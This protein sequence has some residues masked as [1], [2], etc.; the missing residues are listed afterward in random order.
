MPKDISDIYIK[1][2]KDPGFTENKLENQTFVDTV[3]A[4]IYMILMTNKGEVLGNPNFGAD[5]P[6][7]LWKTMLPAS[8][9]QNEIT[10][11][12][13]QYVPELS[14]NDY[15]VNVYILPG[16]TQ[17]VGVIEINLGITSAVVLYK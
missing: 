12:I 1:D 13:T 2:S 17:D 11:Q 6:K 3:I 9:L 5:V 10:D 15:K 8:T 4:K 7:Y 16:K 14:P